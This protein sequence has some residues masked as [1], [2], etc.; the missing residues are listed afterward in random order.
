MLLETEGDSPCLQPSCSLT[1]FLG[2]SEGRK[3]WGFPGRGEQGEM[4]LS[5]A[6]GRTDLAGTGSHAWEF[7]QLPVQLHV[8]W[9][10]APYIV[11][12]PSWALPRAP[13]GL[14]VRKP[15]LIPRV[16]S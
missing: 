5:R 12:S 6:E 13:D 14:G 11:C 2:I 7:V 15:W 4:P 9:A 10:A 16:A 1:S 3:A 8:S